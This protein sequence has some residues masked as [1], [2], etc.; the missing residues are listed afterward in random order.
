MPQQYKR[1]HY[2]IDKRLQGVF[3][4][5]VYLVLIVSAVAITL[6][7]SALTSDSFTLLYTD[8]D[9]QIGHAP[10]LI[11]KRLLLAN[12]II[13]A[14]VGIIVVI[15]AILLSHRIAGPIYKLDSILTSMNNNIIG[16]TIHLRQKDNFKDTANKLTTFN[17]TLAGKIEEIKS[18]SERLDVVIDNTNQSADVRLEQTQQLSRELKLIADFY[19]VINE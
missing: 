1:R 19:T 13:I 14:P 7:M 6:L 11:L 9:L 12:W 15:L 3:A 4:L 2:F 8:N 18:I 16:Q 17:T 5:R 10:L